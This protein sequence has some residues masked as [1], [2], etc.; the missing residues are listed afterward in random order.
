MSEWQY[1]QTSVSSS[2]FISG[3]YDFDSYINAFFAE[4]VKAGWQLVTATTTIRPTGTGSSH[5]ASYHYIWKNLA[6]TGRSQLSWREPPV[7]A[8]PSQQVKRGVIGV[9]GH[10][11]PPTRPA[12]NFGDWHQSTSYLASKRDVVTTN[13]GRRNQIADEYALIR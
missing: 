4:M 2:D 6:D 5:T 7:T 8:D 1:W 11:R 13:Q 12:G 10:G 9:S 3:Q